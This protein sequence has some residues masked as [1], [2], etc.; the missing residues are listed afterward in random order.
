M[1]QNIVQIAGNAFPLGNFGEVLDLLIR[2][3]QF[4]IHAIALGEERVPG[5]DDYRK[6]GGIKQGP[7]VDMQQQSLDCAHNSDRSQ[8]ENCGGLSFERKRK[9][10][11]TS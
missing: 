5:S 2:F 8:P 4:A 9:H 11:C 3:A 1:P 6:Q 7:A 10:R